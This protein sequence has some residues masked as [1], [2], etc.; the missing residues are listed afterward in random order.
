MVKVP[1]QFQLYKISNCGILLYKKILPHFV[2]PSG[3][4]QCTVSFIQIKAKPELNSAWPSVRLRGSWLSVFQRAW[5][6][7][8]SSFAI[9][10]TTLSALWLYQSSVPDSSHSPPQP[11]HWS[12]YHSNTQFLVPVSVSRSQLLWK[13]KKTTT[14]I[15]NLERKEFILLKIPYNS[16]PLKDIRA[17][18][19]GRNL[20]T[21]TETNHGE[22]Y[23]LAYYLAC[24]AD[25]PIAPRTTCLG[26][27]PLLVNWALPHQSFV[28][29]MRH[30]L[31]HRPVWWTFS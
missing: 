18:T 14:T 4:N 16:L 30:R 31:V 26:V 9:H 3:K 2:P 27:A 8:F 21:G 22:C 1:V 6:W 7:N 5:P 20:Y 28:N 17:G 25:L 13:K 29:K 11:K 19:P 12:G 15:S 23:L 24:W 10:S